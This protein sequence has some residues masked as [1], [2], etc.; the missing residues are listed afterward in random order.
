LAAAPGNQI[1]MRP[2]RGWTVNVVIAAFVFMGAVIVAPMFFGFIV[3][4]CVAQLLPTSLWPMVA[5]IVAALVAL[6]C[7]TAVAALLAIAWHQV[8]SRLLSEAE[9]K[10][11]L[12]DVETFSN[13]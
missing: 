12:K 11:L 9:M 8:A 1:G 4:D 2:T 5:A 3:K 10:V 6:V 7:S 13:R